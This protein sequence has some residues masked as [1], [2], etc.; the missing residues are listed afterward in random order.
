[1]IAAYKYVS[2]KSISSNPLGHQAS[3]TVVWSHLEEA[4]RNGDIVPLPYQ[5][6]G[7][8]EEIAEA[9]HSVK[10]ASGYK[11]IVHPQE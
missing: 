8:L 1:M 4:L 9:L 5:F 6:G 10:K 2:G 11:V 3:A 7:G